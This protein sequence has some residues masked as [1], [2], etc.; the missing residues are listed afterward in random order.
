MQPETNP[1][2]E[3]TRAHV[4]YLAGRIVYCGRTPHGHVPVR[5]VVL[6][7]AIDLVFWLIVAAAPIVVVL[8]WDV[9]RWWLIATGYALTHAVSSGDY[10]FDV[11][12][13]LR[14]FRRRDREEVRDA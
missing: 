8:V 9:S 3:S 10:I 11:L 13:A 7:S 5:T 2:S 1:R 14:R 12:T 4:D 6:N